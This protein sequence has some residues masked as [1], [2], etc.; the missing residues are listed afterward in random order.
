MR[1]LAVRSTLAP[2]VTW[3]MMASYELSGYAA[4]S[5]VVFLS[6]LCVCFELLQ[7]QWRKC[8]CAS[9]NQELTALVDDA[10]VLELA[11]FTPLGT[12]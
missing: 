6:V 9:H 4:W 8:L 2:L 10:L 1:A 7:L 11:L 12:S 5:T 3:E